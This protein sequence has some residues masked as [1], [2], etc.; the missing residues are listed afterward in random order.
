MDK[1]NKTMFKINKLE[2]EIS[3]IN[4]KI[5]KKYYRITYNFNSDCNLPVT[6]KLI[7]GIGKYPDYTETDMQ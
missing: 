4:R 1:L 7:T 2:R 5:N 3:S 6:Y